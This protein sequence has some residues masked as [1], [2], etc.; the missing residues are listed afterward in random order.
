MT[1]SGA[2][3]GGRSG[4]R[5]VLEALA[6]NKRN[7]S[8]RSEVDFAGI[9]ETAQGA[10]VGREGGDEDDVNEAPA[11][12]VRGDSRDEPAP[13]DGLGFEAGA[14]LVEATEG[15]A[16]ADAG[17]RRGRTDMPLAK[18]RWS[19]WSV[20]E[21]AW[22]AASRRKWSRGSRSRAAPA[23]RS[24]S[25]YLY[26]RHRTQWV[27]RC[28][29]DPLQLGRRG[30]YAAPTAM[31]RSAS[32]PG[33]AGAQPRPRRLQ[34][35]GGSRRESTKIRSEAACCEMRTQQAASQ[36]KGVQATWHWQC[37]RSRR[38]CLTRLATASG[39]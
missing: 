21:R 16:G 27:R 23:P 18:Q 10:V 35:L 31:R 30:E 11:G 5:T 15:D 29:R 9:D 2:R 4:A 19:M 22:C 32:P 26:R 39:A 24:R 12:D 6:A 37:L 3:S 1:R 13:F 7:G 28:R 20:R 14:A 38:C 8:G 25:G 17:R 33:R 36:R 34:S